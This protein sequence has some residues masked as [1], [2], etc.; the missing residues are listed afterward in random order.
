M[1]MSNPYKGIRK[2][3]NKIEMMNSI[4]IIPNK[5]VIRMRNQDN[6]YIIKMLEQYNKSVG[7]EAIVVSKIRFKKY[8][9][10]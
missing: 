2:R 9:L 10:N 4:K 7:Y 5:N 8:N 3:N 1:W 6:D